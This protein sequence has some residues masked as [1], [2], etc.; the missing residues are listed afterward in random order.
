[1]VKVVLD[2]NVLVSALLNPEG[3][4][5]EVVDA[6]LEGQLQ[7]ILSPAVLDEYKGVLSRGK[8]GFL[9]AD[10]D[11]FLQ[12]LRKSAVEIVPAEP[13]RVSPDPADD[14][15]LECA[16]AAGA[17][18]LVTG[19]LRHF[20]RRFGDVRVVSPADFLREFSLR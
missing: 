20:P 3:A 9:P 7:L 12:A 1:M 2:T 5:A 14:K 6:A 11:A 13:L 18:C 19:N 8:F 16:V 10:V 15:F 17:A 4:P